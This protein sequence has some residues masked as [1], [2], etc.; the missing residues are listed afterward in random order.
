MTASDRIG[1]F[2]CDDN[3]RVRHALVRMLGG[4]DDIDIIGEAQ[5]TEELLALLRDSAADA[6]LLDVNLPGL[7]GIEGLAR[8][9]E[10]GYAK[11]IV[12]M[13]ADRRNEGPARDAGAAGFYYKGE[14]DSAALAGVIRL[15]VAQAR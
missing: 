4:T 11:P 2:V 5:S 1:L 10:S 7:S 3:E 12:V 15:A 13:S 9:R 8:L 14:A 6:V